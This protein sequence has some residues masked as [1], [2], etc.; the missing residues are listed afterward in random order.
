[1]AGD[2]EDIL[3]YEERI[4]GLL[5]TVARLHRRAER[6]QCRPGREGEEGWEGT[7][8][9]PAAS[10]TPRHLDGTGTGQEAHSPDLFA[11]LQHAVSSLERAVF[12]RHRRPPA[13]PLPGEE[14]ARAAK[15]LEELSRAPGWAGRV[16]RRC[17]A[18]AE[19]VPAEVAAALA[20]NA[21]LRAAVGR[22][23]EELGQA[24][25][26]LQ[27]LRGERDRLQGKVRDLRDA[28]SSL[29]ELGGSGS[30][31]PGVS[32]PLRLHQDL[33]QCGDSAQ[34][35]GVQPLR[36]QPHGMQPLSIQ[37][38]SPLSPQPSAGASREQEERLQQLQGC[39]GRLQEVNRELAAALQECKSE[40]ER[41]SME[42]G[43]H[44]SRSTALR[45]A[46]RCSER[47][48]GAYAALLDLLQAKVGREDGARGGAAGEPS[49]GHAQG[50]SPTATEGPQLP[51]PAEPDGREESGASSSPGA[52]STA[53]PRG[54]EEGALREHIRRLRA[55]QAAV[56][57]SLLDAPAPPGV[58]RHGQDARARAER[59]LRDARA[60]L[61]GW[62]RPEKAELLQDLAMLKEAM[63]E[64]RTRLQL[65]EREKRG[66]EVLLAGQGPREAALRLV[67]QHLQW[68][69]E[70]GTRRP[71]SSS[72]SSSSSEGVRMARS[73][74][75]GA[76]GLPRDGTHTRSLRDAQIG[77]GGAAAP[78]NPPDPERMREELLRTS[79]RTEEL[80][81]RAQELVLSLEQ[82]SAASRAQQAQSVTVTT[83]LFQ[84]HRWA[85]GTHVSAGW[86]WG[87]A[88]PGCPVSLGCPRFPESPW[89]SGSPGCLLSPQ[90]LVSPTAPG[91]P[92]SPG[93][94]V[95]PPSLR[96]LG[97]LC[98]LDTLGVLDPPCPL[99][100]LN[101]LDLLNPPDTLC[102]L[103][104]L[105]A[106]GPLV[107]LGPHDPS[108]S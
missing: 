95:F 89:S 39:L 36:I 37:P 64:L 99:G 63:A 2:A 96:P 11:D 83:D 30:D 43:Q 52:Q 45:L 8:S 102:P 88:P 106:L 9:P 5:A 104:P 50:S 44:E 74:L 1:M 10:P 91:S 19:E 69:R 3:R 60:L 20:R 70:G 81:A 53:A 15:S 42:L 84:A 58:T 82:G 73:P 40:A 17:P 21:A 78:R 4:A 90:S 77:R 31:A 68:E 93:C 41:L 66:L 107:P 24:T 7:A 32:S 34:P 100:P 105:S 87:A 12:S 25:A 103:D 76:G 75:P 65:A 51:G 29:E 27:A 38:H 56:E 16:T 13:Q 49:P 54:M 85:G 94:P 33:P 18:V 72:S 26:A 46:L 79:A 101:P 67:L 35:H 28:L 97:A 47:C 62:R 92:W 23:D 86:A 108:L 22:R 57:G 98:P 48:G 80:R 71:P 61:P 6:L 14:W 59:A 55:E